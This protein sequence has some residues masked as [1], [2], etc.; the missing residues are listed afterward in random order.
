[1]NFTDY[2][3][4]TRNYSALSALNDYTK[5]FASSVEERDA[6]NEYITPV[7]KGGKR[8]ARRLTNAYYYGSPYT[9]YRDGYDAKFR[10]E[11][12]K[13]FKKERKNEYYDRIADGEDPSAVRKNMSDF[14]AKNKHLRN[15]ERKLRPNSPLL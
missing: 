10:D 7:T 5:M 6:D 8:M 15:I 9:S 13:M 4:A 1:M 11:I 2:C 14:Y 3:I 12:A